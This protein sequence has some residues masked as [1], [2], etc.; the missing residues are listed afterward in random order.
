MHTGARREAEPRAGGGTRTR[1]V[2]GRAR[3]GR[4]GNA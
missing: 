3:R 4:G 1:L 2:G